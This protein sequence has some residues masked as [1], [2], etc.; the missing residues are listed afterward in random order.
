MIYN[1]IKYCYNDLAIMPAEISK[2]SHRSEC[3]IFDE[4]DML[5]LFTAPMSCIVNL[6]N[7][8]N[9]FTNGH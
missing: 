6:K 9:F 2:I 1:N 8:K 3:Q 7:C 5:P 4:N